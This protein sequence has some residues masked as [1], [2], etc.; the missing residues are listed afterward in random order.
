MT[1]RTPLRASGVLAGRV[2]ALLVPLVVIVGAIGIAVPSQGRSLDGA[3]AV[4]PTLAVLVFTAGLAVDAGGLGQAR[5]IWLRVGA[6]LAVSSVTLPALAWG[7]SHLV[8]GPARG[9]ILSVGVAPSEV[10]SLGLVAIA[11]GE[12]AVSAALLIA[13]SIITVLASGPILAVLSGATSVR[14][15][16][17]LTTLALVIGLPLAAGASVRRVLTTRTAMLDAGRL[18]GVA[19]L[20][21]L[22][23]EVASEV[24]VRASYLGVVAAL[25]GFLAGGGGL[26][27]LLARGLARPARPGVLLPVAMR[28]FAVAAGIA[29][30]AFGPRAVGP[31]GVYGLLVLLGGAVITWVLA[32][33][34]RR[35]PWPSDA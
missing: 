7:L 23:W 6:V 31:L 10:A 19:A 9:G 5:R 13:S 8:S 16:G 21:M 33:P 22:L 24:Q 30:T 2:E 1:G 26:G 14:A 17:L 34:R 3:G 11:G 18:L 15:G 32:R 27:W 4:D 29:A 25:V 12:V 35:L 28:D 20:L